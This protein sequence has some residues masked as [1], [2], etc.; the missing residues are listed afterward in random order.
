METLISPLLWQVATNDAQFTP[1][2]SRVKNDKVIRG[3][4]I[5]STNCVSVMQVSAGLSAPSWKAM[6]VK[7]VSQDIVGYNRAAREALPNRFK[8]GE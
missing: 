3:G 2:H 8:K 7:A 5:G 1:N 4:R 6:P